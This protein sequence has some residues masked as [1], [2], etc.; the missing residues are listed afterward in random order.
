MTPTTLLGFY[1]FKGSDRNN[2]NTTARCEMCLK[3]IGHQKDVS[4]INLVSLLLTFNRCY[5]FSWCFHWWLEANKCWLSKWIVERNLFWARALNPAHLQTSI[6]PPELV[7]FSL[8][9]NFEVRYVLPKVLVT[10]IKT[11]EKEKAE[12]KSLGITSITI[13]IVHFPRAFFHK[14]F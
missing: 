7:T 5:T 2:K 1:L 10:F 12:R 8:T 9:S 11:G 4:D 14:R 13:Y 3:V 6:S